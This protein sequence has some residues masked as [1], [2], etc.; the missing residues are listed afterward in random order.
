MD[1]SSNDNELFR[2]AMADVRPLSSDRVAPRRPRPAPIPH[3]KHADEQQVLADLLSDWFEPADLESGEELFFTRPG[4]QHRL[5]RKLRRGLLSRQAE[6]DLHGMNVP[7]ARA[8][9]VEF[10]A[11]CRL[12]NLRCVRIIH[13]TGRR[14]SNRGPVLKGKVAQWLRQRDEVLAYCSAPRHDG[15]T[16]AAYVLL[17]RL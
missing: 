3:Q 5:V 10:L 14:S 7:A 16:G 11:E 13:G 8:A 12:R 15:G 17:K 6:L 9:V 1:D 4:I 2:A